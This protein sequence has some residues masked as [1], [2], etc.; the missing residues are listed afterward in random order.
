M[1]ELASEV[2][3]LIA[4][5]DAMMGR[6]QRAGPVGGGTLEAM[7]GAA[8]EAIAGLFAD[9]GG[10]LPDVAEVTDYDIPVAGGTIAVRAYVPA[11]AAPRPAVIHLHGGAWVLGSIDWPTFA[12]AAREVALRTGA[13]VL[14]VEYSLAPESRFPVAVE[15]CYAALCW[16]AE[17]AEGLGVDPSRIV[18]WGDSAGGNLA[19]AVC[20]MS[21][22]RSGPR[23]AGQVLEI[24]TPDHAN[25]ESYPS[26]VEFASGYGLEL[27][28]MLAGRDLYFDDPGD[29]RHPYASPMLAEDLSG[30]PPAHILT[31]EFDPLRDNGEA[32]GRRLAEAGVP[33]TIDRM[34]G[35]IHG[36]SVLL[37]PRWE[38]A[39]EW[40]DRLVERIDAA[41]ETAS[42]VPA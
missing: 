21:R 12:A 18:L 20:L 17:R 16:L 2:R 13:L 24:P 9:A 8:A 36:S 41:L 3:E 5:I 22:D 32:Y 27:E 14:A 11:T 15:E 37:H 29:V 25:P 19:A 31:A 34:P 33:A 42:E 26:A 23:I 1:P 10:T 35:H 30:L 7:R 28:G 6:V 4:K 39:R 40:R 38:G